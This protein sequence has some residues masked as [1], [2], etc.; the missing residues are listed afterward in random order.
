MNKRVASGG[1]FSRKSR[2]LWFA[3]KTCEAIFLRFC[4][5]VALWVYIEP[6]NLYFD[7]CHSFV[8]RAKMA[9]SARVCPQGA[10]SRTCNLSPSRFRIAVETV[11]RYRKKIYEA[12]ECVKNNFH[13][14]KK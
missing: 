5:K 3:A 6:C 4:T 9:A 7:I 2:K 1:A 10:N 13:N 12:L 8:C 14:Y 11:L